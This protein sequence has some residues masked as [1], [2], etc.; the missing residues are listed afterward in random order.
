MPDTF[1]AFTCIDCD[2]VLNK[3]AT[4][5][6]G[7]TSE[8]AKK[9]L[10]SFGANSLNIN[11][12]S[13]WSILVR[14]FKSPFVY[15]LILAA[16]L[17]YALGELIDGSMILFFIAI[18]A[19]LG[20]Y[21]EYRSEQT[22][23]LLSKYIAPKATVIRDRKEQSIL[24]SEIVPGDIVK[25]QPGDIVPADVRLLTTAHLL[26][27]ESSLS[28][29]SIPRAKGEEMLKIAN[30]A[31]DEAHNIVFAGSSVVQGQALGV[32]IATGLMAYMGRVVKLMA[33]TERVS[34]FQKGLSKFSNFVLKLVGVTLLMVFVINLAIKGPSVHLGDLILF[35]VALAAAVIPE[36]LPLVITFSLSR[37]AMRL[38][39]HKVVVKRLTAIE[40]LG[41][42]EILCTDKTGTITENVLEV[43]EIFGDKNKVLYQAFAAVDKKSTK[44]DPFDTAL[45]IAYKK[46]ASKLS[47]QGKGK[48]TRLGSL[49]FDPE[50]RR[51]S[52]L[53]EEKSTS[54]LVV[55][56][57]LEAIAP[58]LETSNAIKS[59]SS[60]KSLKTW[61][62]QQESMGRRVMLI[63][64][65]KFEKSTT[66]YSSK[67]EE[68][69]LILTGAISFADPL[70]KSAKSAV[71]KATN[72]G[73]D[74]KIIT[75]DSAVV[76]S[77]I[78]YQIGLIETD[79]E[80]VT[81]NEF[82]AL[83]KSQQLKTALKTKVFA[84]FS[85][86]QKYKVIEMLQEVKEVGYM[87]DG[88]NDAPAL[89]LA[90]VAI[91]VSGASDIAQEA[92]DII[93]LNSSLNTVVNGIQEGREVFANTIK[94]IKITLASNFGNF[95]AIALSTLFIDFLPMLPIQILL[96]NLLTDFPLIAV[97]SDNVDPEDVTRPQ[98]YDLKDFAMI[99]I[100]F[101][102]LSSTFDFIF[103]ASFV[104]ISPEVLQTNWF[105]GSI[106]T[107]LILLYSL[108]TRLPFWR[109]HLPSKIIIILTGIA[110]LVTA[111]LPFTSPGTQIF[112]FTPPTLTYFTTVISLVI[113]YFLCNEA[114]KLV[115]YRYFDK[116]G[117][118]RQSNL[119]LINGSRA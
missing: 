21:Q 64:S 111:T 97:A 13:W 28:G 91:A 84:R 16:I 66:Y 106:L 71:M 1:Q 112:H 70:R 56:G 33:E 78:A 113:I 39:K 42:I 101:G 36:A 114:L 83:S 109:S 8:E 18:N 43:S 76:A 79:Q 24:A 31:I 68:R 35:I 6:G 47:E 3:L 88:I 75:G 118:K 85:P 100:I 107:E 63:A 117:E 52:V 57:A 11:Q 10:K 104:K 50:R 65:K 14:Q 86:T 34:S 54:I 108:R 38:T 41:G 103:F 17:A 29:E 37:G 7:L 27:D 89:K 67:D 82:F 20:F 116:N 81:A 45:S 60:L 77:H 98:S 48:F 99:T 69:G 46:I 40:D 15:I 105:I 12:A 23:R 87:G 92:S 30:P 49:A 96:V 5:E 9:R 55:R 62:N 44:L 94:Y 51:S 2:Q 61:V 93:L 22:I 90:N 95:Y 74:I 53:I 115:Y 19:V 119:H 72:L 102:I 59:S 26:A 73:I 4:S 110:A 80:V 58:Y 25:L 32:V